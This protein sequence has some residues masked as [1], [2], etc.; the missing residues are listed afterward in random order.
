MSHV[1]SESVGQKGGHSD[2][3]QVPTSAVLELGD[4]DSW[5]QIS[6]HSSGS[7]CHC[8]LKEL[9]RVE[10]GRIEM[11]LKRE[12]KRNPR[13]LEKY[14][15]RN[16]SK[17][18]SHFGRVKGLSLKRCKPAIEDSFSVSWEK[19][20]GSLHGNIVKYDS[21]LVFR[22]K[23]HDVVVVQVKAVADFVDLRH[24]QKSEDHLRN[25]RRSRNRIKFIKAQ[26]I[27]K[28]AP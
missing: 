18:Q 22:G 17:A 6:S 11:K 2:S 4:D 15:K 1:R 28:E 21:L 24:H 5:P 14:P 8:V 19:F 27:K 25:W 7:Q 20:R 3:Q 10:S 9:D 12:N 16:S 26:S 13:F 23:H